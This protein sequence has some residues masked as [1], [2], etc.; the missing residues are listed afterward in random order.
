M[1]E[2][3]K[4]GLCEKLKD[5]IFFGRRDDDPEA[6]WGPNGGAQSEGTGAYCSP[7]SFL[8][9]STLSASWA[10]LSNP[11]GHFP[12]PAASDRPSMKRAALSSPETA[13]RYVGVLAPMPHGPWKSSMG[14]ATAE[15]VVLLRLALLAGP[16][17]ASE[18]RL[19]A[20]VASSM[21][22]ATAGAGLTGC[23][24]CG[25]AGV[26]GAGGMLPERSCSYSS[27]LMST[28]PP[29]MSSSACEESDGQ[30]EYMP[31][32]ATLRACAKQ[33]LLQKY[34]L[35]LRL[36]EGVRGGGEAGKCKP[37]KREANNSPDVARRNSFDS[38]DARRK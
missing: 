12:G 36:Q 16:L 1:C 6:C 34:G 29:S 10:S 7:P 14:V 3:L 35:L 22:A 17:M 5:G 24:S 8:A 21:G 31:S 4:D 18:R 26:A 23:L 30:E 27:S 11:K 25:L 9:A 38:D 20:S 32:G 28:S 37:L 19:R 13:G 15:L 2:N 33:G